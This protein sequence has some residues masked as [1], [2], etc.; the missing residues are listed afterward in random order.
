MKVLG[1]VL[2]YSKSELICHENIGT[3]LLRALPN[4]TRVGMD[5]AIFLGS[6][7]GSQQSI[8]TVIKDMGKSLEIVGARLIQLSKQDALILLGNWL[9]M[10]KIKYVLRTAP[11]H[12]SAC[13]KSLDL[14]LRT[15]LS[16]VLDMSFESES[17]WLQATLPVK[18]GGIGVCCATNLASSLFLS[19]YYGVLD[20]VHRILPPGLCGTSCPALDSSLEEWRSGSDQPPPSSPTN[21]KVKA[22]DNPRAEKL[23]KSLLENVHVPDN[24]SRA[25][26]LSVATQELGAWLHALPITSRGLRMDDKILRMAVSFR[27]GLPVCHPHTCPHCNGE[28][29]AQ[30]QMCEE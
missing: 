19:S 13:L 21:K 3:P 7:I 29:N 30:S 22:W 28:G 24:R 27:L 26:L 1:L 17:A 18:Y 10:S 16:K 15:I 14:Q 23:Y 2:N 6:P 11:C 8:D 9:E 4:L 12:S 25:R 5:D 20:L